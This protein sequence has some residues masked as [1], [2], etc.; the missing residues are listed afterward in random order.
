LGPVEYARPLEREGLA[1][2]RGR[3]PGEQLHISTT[4]KA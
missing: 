3:E 4:P 1:R 2:Q